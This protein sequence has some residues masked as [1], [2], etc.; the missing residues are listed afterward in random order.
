M[1]RTECNLFEYALRYQ[2]FLD[3]RTGF[4]ARIAIPNGGAIL[5]YQDRGEDRREKAQES[6]SEI[7]ESSS[8][9]PGNTTA[10]GAAIL[11]IFEAGS[12]DL[13][14][15]YIRPEYRGRGYAERIL[16]DC[17]SYAADR[18]GAGITV[19]V[20]EEREDASL[21]RHLAGKAGLSL[22]GT[23]TMFHSY[24]QNEEDRKKWDVFFARTGRRICEHMEKKGYVTSDFASAP[25]EILDRLR[26]EA[27]SEFPEHLNPFAMI[28]PRDDEFSFLTWKDGRVVTY[29]TASSY[30]E[31]TDKKI[32]QEMMANRNGM[33]RSGV[34]FP[35]LAAFINRTIERNC[36]R[37][38]YTV[39]DSN[40]DMQRLTQGFLKEIIR[41][42]SVQEIWRGEP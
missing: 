19:R 3:E 20:M 32:V 41:D 11:N 8:R 23:T 15:L 22:S 16:R 6:E 10:I 12:Y 25:K 33:L 24:P 29:N 7:Q 38:T 28:T 26:K 2:A 27:G 31:G 30:G 17:R 34:F 5:V 4:F 1:I 14:Y 42:V 13:A 37:V 40:Q 35:A 36:A 39:Y 18:A 9:R 21:L